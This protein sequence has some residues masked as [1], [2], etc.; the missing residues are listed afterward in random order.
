[1]NVGKYFEIENFSNIISDK[2]ENILSNKNIFEIYQKAF[3]FNF[4]EVEKVCIDFIVFHY[5]EMI[6]DSKFLDL[7]KEC[8]QQIFNIYAKQ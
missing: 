6:L 1:M 2:I 7:P 4:D 3:E 8:I 5:K